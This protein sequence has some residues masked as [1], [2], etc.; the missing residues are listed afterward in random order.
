MTLWSAGLGWQ[1]R[2]GVFGHQLLWCGTR[3]AS[4]CPWRSI[5]S[6]P[7]LLLL[8]VKSN[9]PTSLK[10]TVST[11]LLMPSRAN[12]RPRRLRLTVLAGAFAFLAGFWRPASSSSASLRRLRRSH[13]PSGQTG[14]GGGFPLTPQV[15]SIQR[16][17]SHEAINPARRSSTNDKVMVPVGQLGS[18]RSKRA[19]HTTSR[20]RQD[21]RLDQGA[22]AG[23]EFGMA[24]GDPP[25]RHTRLRYK[26]CSRRSAD[27][28]ASI[29]SRKSNIG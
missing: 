7:G 2:S 12:G 16:F 27:I 20:Y 15:Q 8:Q 13:L 28:S 23:A 17:P 6:R 1:H 4:L 18:W 14:S 21:R 3:S 5:H 11:F 22:E 24:S 25:V 19:V 26:A 10:A 9:V 29:R